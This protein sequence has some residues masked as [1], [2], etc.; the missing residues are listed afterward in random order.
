[1]IST[2][3]KTVKNK[4]DKIIKDDIAPAVKMVWLK[5]FLQ[6]MILNI[7]QNQLSKIIK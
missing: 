7:V 6:S 5:G 2:G 1:M 3:Y 4:G